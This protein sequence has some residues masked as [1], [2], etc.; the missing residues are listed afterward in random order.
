MAGKPAEPPHPGQRP[1]GAEP[2][3]A[4]ELEHT[5]PVIFRRYVKDDG[6]ALILYCE[7]RRAEDPPPEA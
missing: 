2:L 3:A 1:A 4:G 5:G 7:Q 6:R